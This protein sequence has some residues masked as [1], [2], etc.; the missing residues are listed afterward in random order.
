MTIQD[1]YEAKSRKYSN[2]VVIL[3]EL[4]SGNIA[5]FNNARTLTGVINL[6]DTTNVSA[7]DIVK[8]YKYVRDKH[9]KKP[10]SSFTTFTK[11]D[12]DVATTKETVTTPAVP[13]DLRKFVGD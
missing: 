9:W 7:D 8:V 10:V 4:E 12:A 11:I 13:L 3:L 6:K 5:V 2:E 1:D